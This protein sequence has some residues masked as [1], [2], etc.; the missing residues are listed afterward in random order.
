M[1]AALE[2]RYRLAVCSLDTVLWC[3]DVSFG[4]ELATRALL[5][6]LPGRKLLVRGNHDGTIARCVRLGFELVMDFAHLEI[7]GHKVTVSH[8]P[9]KGTPD[10]HDRWV[11]R[12]P[13]K[14]GHG[15]FVIHGHTHE[16]TRRVGRR[17][18]VGV[19]AWDYAPVGLESIAAL[20]RS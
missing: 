16:K 3:G 5:D 13:P 8:Y 20:I 7:A 2:R 10:P 19:D 1:N 9:P 12:R 4:D 15:E 14:P 11:D 17:I 18:H 6:R